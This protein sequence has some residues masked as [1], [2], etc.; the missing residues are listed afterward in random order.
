M[1]S[2]RGSTVAS[3][4]NHATAEEFGFS[5]GSMDIAESIESSSAERPKFLH[6]AISSSRR[7]AASAPANISS[8][9]G[10]ANATEIPDSFSMART[11]SG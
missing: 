10:D 4:G 3:S 5:A 2:W 6:L 11:K 7:S 9:P 8:A 1:M